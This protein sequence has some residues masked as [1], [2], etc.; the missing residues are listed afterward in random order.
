MFC[1]D[2]AS[3]KEDAWPLWLL[4]RLNLGGPGR[5][6]AERGIQAPRSWRV[7]NP[8]I[9]VKFVCTR[10]NNGWMSRLENCAK[11]IIEALLGD[12]TVAPKPADRSLL[13]IWAIK[14]AMVFEAL[15]LDRPWV[16]TDQERAAVREHLAPPPITSVWIAKCVES[17]GAY[18]SASDLSG[19]VEESG[20]PM[21]AYVTTMVF[22]P[23]AI[24][25]LR[26][27]LPDTTPA[28]RRITADVRPGP[29]AKAAIPVWP[30]VG[31]ILWPPEVGLAGEAGIDAFSERWTPANRQA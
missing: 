6:D 26:V 19:Q 7:L 4:R 18:C 30:A 16:F 29:W 9:K 14:N 13:A 10:C 12:T 20:A 8:G 23:L 5:V 1:G 2:R 28:V 31:D 21:Q 3:S 22:G 11:P 24:Q 17:P 15:R 25:V 27:A